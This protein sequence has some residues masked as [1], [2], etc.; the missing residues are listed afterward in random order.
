MRPL[1][2]NYEVTSSSRLNTR[3]HMHMAMVVIRHC[4]NQPELRE[5]RLMRGKRLRPRP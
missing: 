5:R 3:G 2:L 4:A 1:L